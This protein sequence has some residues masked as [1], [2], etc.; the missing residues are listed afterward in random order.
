MSETNIQ[1]LTFNEF[2]DYLRFFRKP[3]DEEDQILFDLYK[4]IIEVLAFHQEKL[5]TLPKKN[6]DHARLV[7]Y[8]LHD[9]E[10]FLR[11]KSSEERKLNL[12]DEAFTNHLTMK[13]VDKYSS[14]AYLKFEEEY[15]YS[16]FST[17]ISTINVYLNFIAH[18]LTQLISGQKDNVYLELLNQ[19][20]SLCRTVIELLISGFAKEAL[21]TWR[22]LHEVEA[23]LTLVVD[24]S[25]LKVYQRH[26]LYN[27]AFYH[28]LPQEKCDEL[29]IEIKEKM[30]KLDLKSKD[31]RRYIEYGWISAHPSF[32]PNLHKFN[33]RDGVQRLANFVE[34]RDIYQKASEA[35][36]GSPLLLFIDQKSFSHLALKQLYSSFITIEAHFA[37]LYEKMS[38][39]IEFAYYEEVRALY[40]KDIYFVNNRLGQ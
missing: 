31:T 9:F 15:L 40:L 27:A 16:T 4:E 10:Y 20:F 8:L 6:L 35:S 14:L 38:D 39:K 25:L 7:L 3:I 34:A 37:V 32:D 26:I 30:K 28:L 5:A 12:S 22:S 24:S 21:S 18:K 17:E 2:S 1:I 13:V 19:G 11:G 33:F 23:T 36:H 29:F